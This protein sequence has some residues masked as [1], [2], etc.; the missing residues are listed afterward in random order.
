MPYDGSGNCI[1]LEGER[2]RE[3]ADRICRNRLVS[4]GIP[5]DFGDTVD[6]Y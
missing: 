1:V 3:S 5:H 4:C 2:E 6:W